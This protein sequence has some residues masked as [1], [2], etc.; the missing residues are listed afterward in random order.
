MRTIEERIMEEFSAAGPF[1]RTLSERDSVEI[2]IEGTKVYRLHNSI[3]AMI[4]KDTIALGVEGGQWQTNTTKSRINAIADA[5]H[6][7]R[8]YQKSY[9][10]TWSDGIPYTGARVFALRD[11]EGQV[12]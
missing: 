11:H 8:V 1:Y 7:P 12:V 4:K 5:F 2:T 6:T 10:W 3:V 9:V